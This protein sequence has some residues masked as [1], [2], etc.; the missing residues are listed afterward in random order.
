MA[1]SG[2]LIVPITVEALVVNDDV[3]TVQG[4]DAFVRAQMDYSGAFQTGEMDNA[5]PPP[6]TTDA[7]FTAQPGSKTGNGI[8]VSTYYDG[9]Y[10]KW[11]LPDALTT[12]AQDNQAGETTYPLVPNRWMV[13]RAGG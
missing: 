5:E 7:D 6:F 12:G 3:R 1:D 10:L 4:N 11:R 8:D 2:P 9:V 13:V